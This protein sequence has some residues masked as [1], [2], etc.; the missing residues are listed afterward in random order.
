MRLNLEVCYKKKEPL[1][2]IKNEKEEE[3]L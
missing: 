3:V 1:L 2:P